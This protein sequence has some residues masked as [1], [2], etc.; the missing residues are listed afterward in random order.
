MTVY[1]EKQTLRK[2]SVDT[3]RSVCFVSVWDWR[4]C[5]GLWQQ[6]EPVVFD[7]NPAVSFDPVGYWFDA[8]GVGNAYQVPTRPAGRLT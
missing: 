6:A 5:R 7:G 1:S 8:G 4:C 2:V 3:L